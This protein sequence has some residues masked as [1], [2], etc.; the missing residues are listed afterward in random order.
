MKFGGLQ[1]NSLIDFPG[2]IATLIFTQGCNFHCPYCHNP[3]LIPMAGP[4]THSEKE[5]L[6]FLEKRRGLIEGV[7]ITGGE[8]TLQ[9]DLAGFCR[10][11]KDL[12][13]PIKIDTNGSRPQILAH[14]FSE[15]LVDFVAMDIKTDP[16]NYAPL[17]SP[18][19]VDKALIASI[20]LILESGIDHEFRST[21]VHPFIS[22]ERIARI[23]PLIQ[24]ARRYALQHFSDAALFHPNFFKDKGRGLD[25]QEL[26]ALKKQIAPC[27]ERCEIR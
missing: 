8:P 18:V 16:E 19:A 3:S 2:K 1:K 9:K 13:Y 17:L 25:H 11:V 7:A 4:D 21:C 26:E 23:L 15:K 6:L 22:K 12:A 24:G 27:V 10:K 5:I 14:L 20:Q